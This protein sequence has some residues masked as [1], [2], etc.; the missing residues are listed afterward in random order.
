MKRKKNPFL[1][2]LCCVLAV[3]TCGTLLGELTLPEA[4]TPESL[5]LLKPWFSV[6]IL[7]GLAHLLL[8]PILRLLSAPIGC[9]TLGLFGF[10]ID[11]ALIYLCAYFVDGFTVSG[12][13][14]AVCTAIL[15]NAVCAV[16]KSR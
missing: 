9:I 15:I 3:P 16:T 13:L 8:R 7:L 11:V 12:P 4:I 10:I 6:G 5:I 2:F 1:V 14:Y